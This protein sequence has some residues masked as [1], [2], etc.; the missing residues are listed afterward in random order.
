MLRRNISMYIYCTYITLYRGNKL[1]PFYIGSSSV[2]K[3]NNGYRGSVKSKR[4]KSIW[5]QELIDNPQLFITKIISLHISR[6]DALDK[7]LKFHKT[8]NVVKSPMYI[9]RA[10]AT[11][12]G[13]FGADMSG[14]NNPM[15]GAHRCGINN[16]FYG[17]THSTITRKVISDKN[18]G[19]KYTEYQKTKLKNARSR[20]KYI[21]PFGVFT[22]I[23]EAFKCKDNH[24][25]ITRA[26]MSTYF[27]NELFGFSFVPK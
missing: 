8:L 18:T 26:I 19:N 14:S 3:I 17:K 24:F 22:S 25:K 11:V 10:F 20:G 1:P 21:T 6:K 13:F 9:N 4:Y 2:E 15:Y 5:K 23:R 12:N 27:K 7:E 16:P